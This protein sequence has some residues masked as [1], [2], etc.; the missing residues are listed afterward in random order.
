MPYRPADL[1]CSTAG[2][3][4]Q[5][6]CSSPRGP[7]AA[8][9]CGPPVLSRRRWRRRFGWRRSLPAGPAGLRRRARP[10]AGSAPPGDFGPSAAVGWPSAVP[11]SGSAL[12]ARPPHRGRLRPSADV[13]RRRRLWPARPGE[14]VGEHR[15]GRHHPQQG[16]DQAHPGQRGAAQPGGP[17]RVFGSGVVPR[18]RR[19]VRP[20]PGRPASPMPAC[21]PG[22]ASSGS[23]WQASAGQPK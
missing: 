14:R 21:A 3:C 4:W 12:A 6:R 1:R 2:R 10:P 18:C 19:R 7:S 20:S 17:G 5:E 13:P 16:V 23:P 22:A 15:L 9:W 8:G 11:A